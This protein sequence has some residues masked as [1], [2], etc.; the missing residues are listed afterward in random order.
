MFVVLH[1]G[2]HVHVF[3]KYHHHQA[4]IQNLRNRQCYKFGATPLCRRRRQLLSTN[5]CAVTLT[6]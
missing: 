3:T 2:V 4:Y 5:T 6:D 1:V